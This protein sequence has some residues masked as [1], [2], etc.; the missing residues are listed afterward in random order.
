MTDYGKA[1]KHALVDKEKTQTWLIREINKKTG[2][3]VDSS[4][5]SH[6]FSGQRNAPRVK[7]AI[8][9]ILKVSDENTETQ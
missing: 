2:L 8:Y 3:K 6:I 4:Y 1:V 7:M 9:D 5:L